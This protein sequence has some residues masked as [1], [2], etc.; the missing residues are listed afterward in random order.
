MTNYNFNLVVFFNVN[1]E[2]VVKNDN[3]KVCDTYHCTKLDLAKKW[4]N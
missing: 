4:S 3:F 2:M 1:P